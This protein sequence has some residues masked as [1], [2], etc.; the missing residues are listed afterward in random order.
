MLRRFEKFSQALRQSIFFLP[1]YVPAMKFI[2]QKQ[3]VYCF[4]IKLLKL[5]FVWVCGFGAN[6][7]KKKKKKKM[8]FCQ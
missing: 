4:S 5:Q 2:E 6:F 8:I 7:V 1:L 3:L